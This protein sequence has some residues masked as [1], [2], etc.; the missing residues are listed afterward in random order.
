MAIGV[1]GL[2][3]TKPALH[4]L[5]RR[6]GRGYPARQRETDGL[7]KVI[8]C[9]FHVGIG[10]SETSIL[11]TSTK[12]RAPLENAAMQTGGRVRD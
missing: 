1:E 7:A 6:D 10:Q 4:R 3:P 8:E 5:A 2:Q 12:T 11:P 9:G